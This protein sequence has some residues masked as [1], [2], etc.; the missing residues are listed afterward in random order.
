MEEEGWLLQGVGQ[1]RPASQTGEGFGRREGGLKKRRGEPRKKNGEREGVREEGCRGLGGGGE[2]RQMLKDA[3]KKDS[4]GGIR[5]GDGE[6]ET[7]T[8]A[9]ERAPAGDEKENRQ[10]R[11]PIRRG[12]ELSESLGLIDFSVKFVS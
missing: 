10:S 12:R 1:W 7:R 11:R 5:G 6:G 9:D 3:E 8:G 2:K 4:G